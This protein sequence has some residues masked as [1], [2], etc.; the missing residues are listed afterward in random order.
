MYRAYRAGRVLRDFLC[1]TVGRKL[2]KHGAGGVFDLLPVPGQLACAE[3]ATLSSPCRR[4]GVELRILA[5]AGAH[6]PRVFGAVARGEDTEES[7]LGQWIDSVPGFRRFDLRG[8]VA[9]IEELPGVL[10]D[11]GT[12]FRTRSFNDNVRRNARPW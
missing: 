2:A 9:E 12:G 8:V 1:G 4:R 5:A 6:N 3:S 11:I 7:D 10:V